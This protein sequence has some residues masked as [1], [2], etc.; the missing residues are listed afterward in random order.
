MKRIVVASTSPKINMQD[1]LDYHCK[2]LVNKLSAYSRAHGQTSKGGFPR[3]SAF[4]VK[5]KSAN[6]YNYSFELYYTEPDYYQNPHSK[7]FDSF[8]IFKDEFKGSTTEQCKHK[9]DK[10]VDMYIEQCY[11][12]YE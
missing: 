4:D 8:L 5:S 9:I 3:G 2:T 10:W 7:F 11:L 6:P 1:L 12:G